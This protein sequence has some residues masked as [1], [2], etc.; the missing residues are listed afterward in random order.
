MSSPASRRLGPAGPRPPGPVRARCASSR[1]VGWTADRR[2]RRFGH[3]PDL[4]PG[5]PG[6]VQRP[7]EPGCGGG[8][9]RARRL[10]RERGAGHRGPVPRGGPRHLRRQRSSGHRG[11]VANLATLGLVGRGHVLTRTLERALGAGGGFGLV[12]LDPPYAYEGW[13]DLLVAL[14]PVLSPTPWSWWNRTARSRSHRPRWHQVEDLRRY[15]GA[16]RYPTGAPS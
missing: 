12:L 6:A 16:V 11:G 7:R 15:G 5:A 3:R 10:R 8:T 14:V 2:A 1:A 4:R 13:D 9:P